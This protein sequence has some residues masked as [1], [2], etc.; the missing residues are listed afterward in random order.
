MAMYEQ[1]EQ[2]DEL[3]EKY[4]EIEEEETSIIAAYVDENIEDFAEVVK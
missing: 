2:F 3:E 1:F 4:M